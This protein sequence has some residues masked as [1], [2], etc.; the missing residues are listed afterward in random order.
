MSLARAKYDWLRFSTNGG[1]EVVAT[2]TPPSGLPLLVKG[3][4]FKHH[5]SIDTDGVPI[6]SKNA[7]ISFI[8]SYLTDLEYTVRDTNG[9]INLR[10]HR[11][12]FADSSGVVMCILGDYG[13]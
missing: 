10:N 1:F 9:D 4:G 11:V 8:E 2:L 13:S 3:L 5:T 12:S 7:H 6:N